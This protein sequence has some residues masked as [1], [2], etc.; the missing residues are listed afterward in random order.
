MRTTNT[1][2]AVA[3]NSRLF[4]QLCAEND[5]EYVLRMMRN[6][7]IDEELLLHIEVIWL[8]KGNCLRRFYSLFSTVVEFF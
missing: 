2:K 5:E 8:S 3:F 1:I 6:N 7:E 4:R